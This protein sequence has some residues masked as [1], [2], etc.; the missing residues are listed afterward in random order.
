ML[1]PSAAGLPV[2]CALGASV[3]PRA[4][5]DE[6]PGL[7][8]DAPPAP[9]AGSA[10]VGAALEASLS[11]R[12]SGAWVGAAP[13]PDPEP[14]APLVAVLDLLLPESSTKTTTMLG[15]FR[16]LLLSILLAA[17]A[18]GAELDGVADAV[19]V[20]AALVGAAARWAGAALVARATPDV[21]GSALGEAVLVLPA[22]AEVA[23]ATA[24]LG[25]EVAGAEVVGAEV[26]GAE[27]AGAGVAGAE[28]AVA[29]AAGAVVADEALA[30]AAAGAGA[31]VAVAVAVAGACVLLAGVDA[32]AA[33][34]A[35]LGL[36]AAAAGAP[37]LAG[38]PVVGLLE[39]LTPPGPL[40]IAVAPVPEVLTDV[41]PLPTSIVEMCELSTTFWLPLP[42]ALPSIWLNTSPIREISSPLSAGAA[43]T[44]PPAAPPTALTTPPP[45]PLL[46]LSPFVE[47]WTVAEPPSRAFCMLASS[48]S[49]ALSQFWPAQAS[50]DLN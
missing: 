43:V 28:V 37:A 22:G 20:G 29:E 8:V 45:P 32:A 18:E 40:A 14:P 2:E 17:W 50:N 12:E 3:E 30:A 16:S 31:V 47:A 21:P 38:A 48:V 26:A 42:T 10:V 6:A 39:T 19:A 7:L 34:G 35:A 15:S 1:G 41:V 49:S 23:V 9:P 11:A 4:A 5:L 44:A 27:V 25:A 24:A 13:E 36:E 33:C 46:T